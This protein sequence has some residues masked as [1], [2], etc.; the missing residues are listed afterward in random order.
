MRHDLRSR[1]AAEHALRAK[2][3]AVG[4][5]FERRARRHWLLAFPAPEKKQDGADSDCADTGPDWDVD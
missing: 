4:R 3:Y 5:P 1:I 2:C